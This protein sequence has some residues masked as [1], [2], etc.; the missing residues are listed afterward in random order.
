LTEIASLVVAVLGLAW[1]AFVLVSPT[2]IGAFALIRGIRTILTDD[3]QRNG[4]AARRYLTAVAWLSV[5][6]TT[7]SIAAV[8][9]AWFLGLISVS[10]SSIG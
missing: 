9:L 6:G 5:A 3:S 2:A 8:I 10:R 1:V 7:L 4:R